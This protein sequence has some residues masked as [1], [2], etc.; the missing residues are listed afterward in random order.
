MTTAGTETGPKRPHLRARDYFNVTSKICSTVSDFELT[1][2]FGM[3]SP[4]N[5]FETAVS[6]GNAAD[7]IQQFVNDLLLHF[8]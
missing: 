4:G 3:N 5:S 2:Q 7:Y 1:A 8:S 6:G